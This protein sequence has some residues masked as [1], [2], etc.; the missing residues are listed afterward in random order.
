MSMRSDIN[1]IMGARR[2]KCHHEML[3]DRQKDP[4]IKERI[5]KIADKFLNDEKALSVQF[6]RTWAQ[7][8]LCMLNRERDLR[9]VI[10]GVMGDD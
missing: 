6:M 9:R 10:K 1:K 3:R 5:A 4:I 8:I 2:A 7:D